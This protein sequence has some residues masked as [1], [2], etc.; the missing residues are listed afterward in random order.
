[1]HDALDRKKLKR[2]IARDLRQRDKQRLATLR[3][4]IRAAKATKKRLR[5]EARGHCKS[6]KHAL[7]ERQ[8]AERAALREAQK[9]TRQAE[10]ASCVTGKVTAASTGSALVED[11]R[12]LLRSERHEQG[13]VRRAGLPTRIKST[14]RERRQEDDD[15]V[16]SNLSPELVVVFN[17]VAK[18]IK[19]NSRRSRTEAFLEWVNENPDEVLLEQQSDADQYLKDLLK[20]E[21]LHKGNVRK[22][23]RYRGSAESLSKRLADVPF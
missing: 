21:K 15:R 1:M 18:R 5:F 19:G 6:G 14:S 23:G 2:E 10:R 11:A 16:R 7:K 17:R 13:V 8:R 9:Q 3:S 12:G 22:A 20:A 4:E